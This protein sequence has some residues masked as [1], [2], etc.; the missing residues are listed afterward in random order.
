MPPNFF[1]TN[2]FYPIP[3]AIILSA[4][5]GFTFDNPRTE[6]EIAYAKKFI[7]DQYSSGLV[8]AL[9]PHSKE[10]IITL[11]LIVKS[12]RDAY[13]K[14]DE[15]VNDFF[16]GYKR[17]NLFD[18][19]AKM[20]CVVRFDDE[21]EVQRI[22]ESYQKMQEKGQKGFVLLDDDHPILRNSESLIN[23]SHLLSLLAHTEEKSYF[24]RNF[25]LDP[26]Q[27]SERI[28]IRNFV[29][30]L[31]M[32][33]TANYDYQTRP[34][35]RDELS[36]SFSWI[37]GSKQILK[38]A[39]L[40]EKAFENGDSDKL[41]YIGNLL[42]IVN[43]TQDEKIKLLIL[44]SIIEL[45]VTRNPD[46]SRFNV[47]DSINKQFQLKAGALIFLNNKEND[48]DVL[49]KRLKTIYQQRSNIAHGNFGELE[50]Y[51]R[52]L[53]KKEGEEEYFEDLVADLYSYVRAILE[54]YLKDPKFVEFI[55][56]G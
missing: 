10:D 25:I 15:Y 2:Y 48:I 24:G 1:L 34:E 9:P 53:S 54:E 56:T 49:K 18:Y 8:N 7:T 42:G 40:F 14:E 39:S 44:T 33:Y 37:H 52:K 20:W 31:V 50:N 51:K 3:E 28:L 29:P 41:L 36:W 35:Y 46:T 38:I 19:F 43:R 12:F 17:K 5:L 30:H 26:D 21:G 23:Y 11:E 6:K 4:S 32:L 55:K 27:L 16:K 13:S 22:D 45:L 47:E